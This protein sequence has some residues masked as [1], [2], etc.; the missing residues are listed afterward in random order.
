MAKTKLRVGLMASIYWLVYDIECAKIVAILFRAK[1]L[2]EFMATRLD[3]PVNMA[4]PKITF[5]M[6]NTIAGNYV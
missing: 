3:E 6:L 5:R 1:K 4:S 2:Y